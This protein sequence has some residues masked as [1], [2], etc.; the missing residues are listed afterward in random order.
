MRGDRTMKWFKDV[1]NLD[2]LRKMYKKLVI[3]HH[4]DNCGSDDAIKEINAEYDVLFKKL[5]TSYEHSES[6][7][8]AT[9]RQRQAYDSNKDI[10]IREMIVKLSCFQE[11]TIE[12]CGTWIYVSGNTRRYKEELKALGMHYA[13]KKK[14]WYIHWDDYVKHGKKSS[15]MSHIRNKYGSMIVHT[16]SN[17]EALGMKAGV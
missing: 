7:Q 9:D 13:S 16:D 1:A 14:C 3:Q 4:P 17:N 6:Y 8:N 11:L 5:K 10:K 2:E 12:L 15:S